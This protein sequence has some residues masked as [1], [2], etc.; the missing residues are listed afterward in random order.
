VSGQNIQP[1]ET[2]VQR[3]NEG[4]AHFNAGRVAEAETCFR[5]AAEMQPN[6]PLVHLN[7]GLALRLLRRPEEAAEA[8]RA[9]LRLKNDLADASFQLGGTLT[10]LRRLR[11]AEIAFRHTL[12][13]RPDYPSGALNLGNTLM[14]IDE[15]ERALS[16]YRLAVILDPGCATSTNNFGAAM[17]SLCREDEAAVLYRRAVHL[18]PSSPEYHKNL[19]CCGLKRGDFDE[20]GREYEWREEQ[21][22]WKWKRSFPGKERWNGEPLAGRTL[23]VHFEQGIGDTFQ[24]IRYLGHAKALGAGRTIFEC[25][26]QLKRFLAGVPGVDVLVGHGEPLPDFDVHAPLMS[27]PYLC[28]STPETLPGGVPYI[29]AEPELAAAWH[30]RIETL[31]REGGAFR[32]GI[33]WHANEVNRSIPLELFEPIAR[34]PGVRLYSLQKVVGLDQLERLRERLGIIDW[35]AEMD[36]GPDGFVD[37]AAVMA[38]M[39]LIIS[40][41]TAVNHLAGA[42]GLNSM[43][44]MR[45]F[46]DWRWMRVPD[47]TQWYPTMRLFRMARRNDWA[48][49]MGR[50]SAEVARQAAETAHPAHPAE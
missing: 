5:Q 11:E 15:P 3:F 32:I 35:T 16:A 9:A 6:H 39:H 47:H 1:A 4:A 26:P 18:L 7:R 44:V 13:V 2:W 48:E 8:L 33:N 28:R 19:G 20:G 34:I 27:M 38:N 17:M 23:L 36:A 14:H 37:T 12:A 41:D 22:V 43:L 30:R 45:W 21:A 49:V 31:G 25:Q 50:V 46:G 24:F 29:K 10:D 40:C 42:M